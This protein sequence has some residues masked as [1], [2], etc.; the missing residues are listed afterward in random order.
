MDEKEQERL[1]DSAGWTFRRL[2]LICVIILF[3][4]GFYLLLIGNDMWVI[5]HISGFFG[6]IWTSCLRRVYEKELE[7]L[8]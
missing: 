4:L 5:L 1:M 3:V 6:L 8:K 2:I 7:N